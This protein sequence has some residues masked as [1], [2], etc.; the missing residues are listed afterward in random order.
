MSA[1]DERLA[2]ARSLYEALQQYEHDLASLRKSPCKT[3]AELFK[4]N[5]R[6]QVLRGYTRDV[7]ERLQ[8][9]GEGPA[10]V[11]TN[12]A[13]SKQAVRIDDQAINAE[14][15]KLLE[16]AGQGA[17]KLELR[18]PG[19]SRSSASLAEREQQILGRARSLHTKQ[20]SLRNVA[21]QSFRRSV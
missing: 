21:K 19:V 9:I 7:R 17:P 18:P 10:R 3:E 8:Q 14:L 11:E 13:A 16:K 4:R 12:Q 20:Q 1:E 5:E 2:E 15:R 6:E